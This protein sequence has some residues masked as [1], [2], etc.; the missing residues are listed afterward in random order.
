MKLDKKMLVN[1]ATRYLN[2]MFGG[3]FSGSSNKQNF[4]FDFGYPVDIHFNQYYTMYCR[5]GIARAGIQ[6]P[7]EKTWRDFPTMRLGEEDE[8]NEIEKAVR[9]AFDRIQFWEKLKELDEKSRVHRYAGL[10]F[11]VGDGMMLRDPVEQVASGL[12]GLI[13]IIPAYSVQLTVQE[14]DENQTS[15]TYGKPLMYLFT[16]SAVD[17]NNHGRTVE[18]HHSRVHIWSED[19]TIYSRPAIEAGFNDLVNIEKI[20]GSG[21]EG[22]W[23]EAKS[24]PVLNIDKDSSMEGLAQ[25]LGVPIAELPDKMDEVVSDWQKGFDQVLMTQG[26]DVKKLSMTLPQPAQFLAGPLQSFAASMPIPMKVL[27]GSQTGERASTEDGKEWLETIQARRKNL[28]MPHIMRIIKKLQMM[29]VFP[30]GDWRADWT[31]LSE[32]SGEAKTDKAKKMADINQKT[33]GTGERVF[34]IDEIR[35]EMDYAPMPDDDEMNEDLDDEE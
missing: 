11:R 29:G 33:L 31:D 35:A 7:V 2:Q 25:M 13:E 15:D 17:E 32:A 30:D 28:V 14:F 8:E 4:W 1:T 12:T 34:T 27:L 6:R 3:Y 10:I 19:S 23:K 24:A 20:N 18:V 21:G 16:E 26:M 22:F 5:N 9:E